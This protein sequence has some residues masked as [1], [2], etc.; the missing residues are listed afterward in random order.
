M[1]EEVFEPV[2]VESPFV[3]FLESLG[4]GGLMVAAAGLAAFVLT[5]FVVF[6]GKGSAVGPALLLIVPL[7]VLV[8]V[9]SVLQGMIV[10]F[11]VISHS[12]N[13]IKAS[14]VPA[15]ISA[16]LVTPIFGLLSMAPSYVLALLFLVYR[17]GKSDS[18][19]L[20]K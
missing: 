11:F 15:A 3:W 18:E 12:D 17:S 13:Q 20:V 16:T 8:S 7:P 5:L 19:P 4:F 2:V 1:D 14:E 6:R 9:F 10:S